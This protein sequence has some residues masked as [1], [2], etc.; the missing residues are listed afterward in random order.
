MDEA[1][2][3]QLLFKLGVN[4]T[5]V[6][7]TG[8]KKRTRWMNVTCPFAAFTHAK[9]TDTNPSF[10]ITIDD[11]GRS[12]Y[13]CLSCGVKG[14]L[15]AMPSKLGGYRKED[16]SKLRNW[17]E[18]VEVNAGISI[19]AT[20][21]EE[22]T[23]DEKEEAAKEKSRPSPSSLQEYPRAL[24]LRYLHERG[25]KYPT[26]LKLD[27]R[28]DD[29]QKR[30]LFPCYDKLD[31]FAGFTGRSIR[32]AHTYDRYNPKVRDYF[33]LD[34]RKLFLRLPAN[35]A[36]RR[37]G[38]K[39]IC[40]GLVDYAKLVQAG[41]ANAHAILGTALTPEKLDILISE[42]DPVYFFMDNDMA[43]W[44]SLFGVP[45]KED[46]EFDRDNAWAYQLY[47]ELAVWIVPYPSPFTSK[48]L[49]PG[50]LPEKTLHG[51]IERAW[52][53]TGE[54]PMDDMGTPNLLPLRNL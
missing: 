6:S 9:G 53:F 5:R 12:H 48:N 8:S 35:N 41:Y 28:Y 23:P 32:P 14:R 4:T 54:A 13:K 37:S 25:L 21:W 36:L 26:P 18:L 16:Y 20:D 1:N 47:K 22:A 42:G 10:G 52:L 3:R 27:L 17:A 24:G 51:C 38:K 15:A 11:K 33:G 29:Y 30:V 45:D 2:I 46:G 39:I 7:F 49:D 50:S 40:E 34:K 43:G 31:R 19:P 44:T